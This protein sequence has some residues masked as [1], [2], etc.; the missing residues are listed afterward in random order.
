MPLLLESRMKRIFAIA[1][2]I[3]GA[4]IADSTLTPDLRMANDAQATARE[5]YPLKYVEVTYGHNRDNWKPLIDDV[6]L[7][8]YG[9]MN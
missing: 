4:A 7:Y 2:L 9:S 8:F 6:L 5:R 1:M 3:S